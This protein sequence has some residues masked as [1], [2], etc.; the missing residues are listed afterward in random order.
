MLQIAYIRDNEQKVITALSKKNFDAT[1]LI[2][3]VIILDENRRAT[4]LEMDN[5]LAE[6]NKL[7]KDIG[8]LMKNG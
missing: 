2:P 5:T 6:A 4:Q 7:S 3:E 1:S 8:D